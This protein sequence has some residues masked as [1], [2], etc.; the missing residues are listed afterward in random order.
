[1]DWTAGRIYIPVQR[2]QGKCKDGCSGEVPARKFEKDKYVNAVPQQGW[3]ERASSQGMDDLRPSV[4]EITAQRCMRGEG[5]KMAS[6]PF[7]HDDKCI[8]DVGL[9]CNLYYH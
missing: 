7:D 5:G 6:C 4:A 8:N 1:V 2:C 3:A 9:S